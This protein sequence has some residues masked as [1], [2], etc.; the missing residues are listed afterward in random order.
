MTS[1]VRVPVQAVLPL[2]AA[3]ILLVSTLGWAQS[4]PLPSWNETLPKF[5]LIDFV[6]TVTSEGSPE[7]LAVEQRIAVFDNDG[8]LWAE[9]PLYFQVYFIADRIRALASLH[10]QWQ[11][12]EPF[13]SVLRGELHQAFFGE[14]DHFR[15]LLL[16]T[17]GGM[18][19]AEFQQQVSD[20]IATAR[21][22]QSGKLLTEMVYRPM[23]ELLDYLRANGF[24]TFIVSGGGLQF[25]RPWSE[26][27]YG[28]PPEQVI[29]T[30]VK[31]SYE[32]RQGRPVIRRQQQ[33][34][35]FNDKAGKPLAINHH[36]GRR[37]VMA[38]GN[39]D[40]DFQML[41]WVTS[42]QGPRLGL[43]VHHTDGKREYAYDRD[44]E[45]GR[46]SQAL[47]EA[48]KRNWQVVDIKED[49]NRVFVDPRGQ[50]Q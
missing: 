50:E 29:G 17:H 11:R 12:Q 26:Q 27:V 34:D 9:Q 18:S 32:Q 16:A 19:E 25:M 38:F 8:T 5:Q 41:E 48:A 45:I 10:P 4:D 20:W 33:L 24:K 21:H 42:G 37:P 1:P 2:M 6:V 14:A 23:V 43:L 31:T 44:S 40:G 46:L 39:S 36:I 15:K 47:D 3:A 35:F 22:P 28:I 7:Y 30:T 49:W 13:A